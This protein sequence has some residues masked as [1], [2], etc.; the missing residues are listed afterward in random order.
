M[1]AKHNQKANIKALKE[2]IPYLKPEFTLVFISLLSMLLSTFSSVLRPMILRTA[3]DSYILKGNYPGLLNLSLILLGLIVSN[4][5]FSFLGIYISFIISQRVIF[6]LRMDL[7][8]HILRLAISFLNRTP[9]GVLITRVTND[10]ESLSDLISGGGLQLINDFILLALTTAFL[11][12][13]NWQLTIIALIITPFLVYII[14]YFSRLLRIA[15]SL[16]RDRLT[17]LN[18]YLQENL[19]GISIIKIFGRKDLNFSKF[20]EIA[21]KYRDAVYNALH[22]DI[23]FN[24]IVNFSAY[25]SNTLVI[26]FGGLMV[27]NGRTTI[28]TLP[29]FLMYLQYFYN[30]LRQL[31]ERFNI[32]QDAL[33][34]IDKISTILKNKEIIP[35]PEKPLEIEIKGEI[36]FKNVT[37]AYEN[38]IVL[39][40]VSFKIKPGERIAIVGPTGAGKTTIMN[41]I[42]RL[43]DVND[44]E[45]LIDSVNIKH[46]RSDVLRKNIA[47]VL[48][49]VFIF[50]GTLLENITLG[51]TDIPIENVYKAAKYLNAH[52]F[53]MSLPNGYDTELTSEGSNLSLGQ[54]QLISF[55]RALV[56]NPKILLLDE[57][58]SSVD[59]NTESLIQEGIEKIMKGRTS[60][61]IAHRLSTIIGCD[62]IFVLDRGKIIEEGNHEELINKRGFYYELYTT[63]F[64]EELI[65]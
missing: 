24:Q 16:A 22:K 11:I 53:I 59:T 8:N 64:N 2:F 46:L 41:L 26:I 15:Y 62:R 48:Q 29:A 17:Q 61:A 18:I 33:S 63:Q 9:V 47:I 27:I 1:Q 51:R 5:I 49:D 25:I 52:D 7:F 60:I 34:S 65:N 38:E 3:I 32:L 20:D 21:Q 56:Y 36:E 50:K 30:P 45:I 39:N 12:Y 14:I 28:G 57:A 44:G 42:L 13:I 6:R 10:T 31:G 40:N 55:V 19:S 37:F 23:L 54:K 58:T 35:E 4:Y 43:Y